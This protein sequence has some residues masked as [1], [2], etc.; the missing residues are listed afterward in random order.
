MGFEP[1]TP[2]GASDFES[3]LDRC[4]LRPRSPNVC[5]CFTL[6]RP[7]LSTSVHVVRQRSAYWLQFGYKS[8]PPSPIRLTRHPAALPS[9]LCNIGADSRA[10]LALQATSSGPTHK[11]S[12]ASCCPHLAARQ[13]RS[14][15][16]R[17][18]T[19]N[20]PECMK[21]SWYPAKEREDQVDPEMGA[22][23]HDQKRSQGR[24]Q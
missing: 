11:A 6:G 15:L 17:P 21:C 20:Q 8:V 22:E 7:S 19:D 4:P 10:P 16:L 12:L 9:S 14:S 1:T 5:T 18:T 2:C 24:K 23:T 13:R 3:Y